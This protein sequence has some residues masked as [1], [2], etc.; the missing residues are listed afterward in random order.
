MS[1]RGP[2]LSGVSELLQTAC[3]YVDK[4]A[5]AGAFSLGIKLSWSRTEL[6]SLA[7]KPG[8]Q[9]VLQMEYGKELYFSMPIYIAESLGLLFGSH[10]LHLWGKVREK[11][12]AFYNKQNNF[13]FVKM[14]LKSQVFSKNEHLI[15]WKSLEILS[16]WADF[17]SKSFFLNNVFGTQLSLEDCARLQ[18]TLPIY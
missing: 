14:H 11:I 8:C 6:L 2:Q 13:Y 10:I 3:C 1:C 15:L 7:V 12:S 4:G 18:S 9:I 17:P 5:L 16:L